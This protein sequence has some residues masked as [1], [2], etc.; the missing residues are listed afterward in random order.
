MKFAAAAAAAA[1]AA[2]A[3]VLLPTLAS[4]QKPK[5]SGP[6]TTGSATYPATGKVEG[7]FN[8]F[9]ALMQVCV[10]LDACHAC[11]GID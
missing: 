10:W 7:C 3:L 4:A 11:V 5:T 2:G 1:A 9:A 6:Q 8:E